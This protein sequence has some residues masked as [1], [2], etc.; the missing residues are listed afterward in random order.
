MRIRSASKKSFEC[1]S[2]T[3]QQQF[4]DHL[5]LHHNQSSFKLSPP[6]QSSIYHFLPQTPPD[7]HH[8]QECHQHSPQ[9]SVYTVEKDSRTEHT[10][11]MIKNSEPV[12]QDIEEMLNDS[13]DSG[14]TCQNINVKEMHFI[15]KNNV[16]P[17]KPIVTKDNI[18]YGM[19]TAKEVA[20]YRP[21]TQD[22]IIR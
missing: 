11:D 15:T 10:W 4:Q 8:K 2:Y 19:I 22:I 9:N 14:N 1:N 16:P 21:C 18:E 13:S 7:H 17:H 5:F 6:K 12:Y 20:K 3:E